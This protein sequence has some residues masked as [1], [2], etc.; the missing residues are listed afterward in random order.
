MIN[1]ETFLSSENPQTQIL[2]AE[3]ISGKG[4]TTHAVCM[5]QNRLFY[6]S[7]YNWDVVSFYFKINFM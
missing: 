3:T 4:C 1:V 6:V 5:I 2:P 7:Y